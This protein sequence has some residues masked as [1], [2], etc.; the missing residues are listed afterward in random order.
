M[1][2]NEILVNISF[3]EVEWKS[4][5]ARPR[6]M[7]QRVALSAPHARQLQV[8]VSFLDHINK[9]SDEGVL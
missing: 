4:I 6:F 5:S 3:H 2:R 9:Y 8:A 1:K 7:R